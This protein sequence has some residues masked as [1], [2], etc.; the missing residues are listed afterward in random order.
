MSFL[1]RLAKRYGSAGQFPGLEFPG[2]KPFTPEIV[3]KLPRLSRGG[4]FNFGTMLE[5]QKVLRA[6]F[7]PVLEEQRKKFDLLK[8][9]EISG[10]Q[11]RA[12]TELR[13]TDWNGLQKLETEKL[14]LL[15][16]LVNRLAVSTRDLWIAKFETARQPQD[17]L[18]E[19]LQ[20]LEDA[21]LEL[22]VK[23]LIQM[24]L[25][26]VQSAL[27]VFNE[28]EAESAMALRYLS[29]SQLSDNSSMNASRY[30]FEAFTKVTGGSNGSPK[31]VLDLI[32]AVIEVSGLLG[33]LGQLV[34]DS[35]GFGPFYEFG[36]LRGSLGTL[37][38]NPND[39][40]AEVQA[41]ADALDLNHAALSLS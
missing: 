19:C 13:E 34:P 24:G 21:R 32:G 12:S 9:A 5:T 30:F 3:R 28:N 4:T 8:L 25:A 35:S 17:L 23:Q 33:D 38:L 18:M 16:G 2:W 29:T 7:E 36:P 14:D 31:D 26:C 15:I 40:Q 1:A 37:K 39:L 27:Y 41:L 6:R 20:F 22:T 11:R 10:V